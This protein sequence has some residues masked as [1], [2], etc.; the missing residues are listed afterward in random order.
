VRSQLRPR[1]VLPLIVVA[2]LGLGVRVLVVGGDAAAEPAAAPVHA[3]APKAVAEQP[4]ETETSGAKADAKPR[5]RR[6]PA[7]RVAPDVPARADLD[8][9]L[10][11]YPVVVVLLYSPESMVDRLAT[12][13]AR[14]GAASVGAGFL[15]VD[16]SDDREIEAIATEYDVRDAPALLVFSAGPEVVTKIN[17]FADRE[18]V[19]QAAENAFL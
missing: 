14:A 15:A 5:P 16:V 13:E 8:R 12:L 9:A 19:A 10:L 3:P 17:G 2:V 7:P 18:T 4:A 11:H 6:R 1:V